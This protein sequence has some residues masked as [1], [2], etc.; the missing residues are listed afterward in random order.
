MRFT[1]S[2]GSG[3]IILCT[4][5][6]A[7][8]GCDATIELTKA[9]FDATSDLTDGTSNAISDLTQPTKEFLSSTTPGSSFNGNNPA[10]TR[11]KVE[12][13]VVYTHENLRSDI[14]QGHGEYLGSLASLAGVPGD[15]QAEFRAYMRN[16][17]AS[18]FDDDLPVR[19]STAR[20]VEAAWSKGFGRQ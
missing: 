17:Y 11:Q 19:D 7:L 16:A 8:S 5:F 20:V 4:L 3:A 14:S 10:R 13:F 2:V 15:R 18:M 6:L 1:A 12:I 9:P